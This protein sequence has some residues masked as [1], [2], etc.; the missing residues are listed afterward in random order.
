MY[1]EHDLTNSYAKFFLPLWIHIQTQTH[2]HTYMH[3]YTPIHTLILTSYLIYTINNLFYLIVV[4][5]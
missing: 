2:K 1:E 4:I 5:E 3:I